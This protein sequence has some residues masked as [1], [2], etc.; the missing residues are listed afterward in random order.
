MSE[1]YKEPGTENPTGNKDSPG[2]PCVSG[3][4]VCMGGGGDT[5]FSL[6]GAQQGR[7]DPGSLVL[8]F[9]E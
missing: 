3:S 6:L 2:L 7:S 5:V 9:G 4:P 8:G 1:D